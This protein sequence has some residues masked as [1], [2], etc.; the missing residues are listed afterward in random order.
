MQSGDIISS[1]LCDLV[2]GRTLGP[3]TWQQPL[4]EEADQ[5][6]GDERGAIL[7][8]AQGIWGN[9]WNSKKGSAVSRVFHI[10]SVHVMSRTTAEGESEPRRKGDTG[11]G[12][13]NQPVPDVGV[14]DRSS[15]TITS[16]LQGDSRVLCII[17]EAHRRF[18]MVSG[19]G[20]QRE[21][22]RGLTHVLL[23]ST[24]SGKRQSHG[25]RQ[26]GRGGGGR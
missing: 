16:C 23:H 13:A 17:Y 20:E 8:V 15:V 10:K 6:A 24:C 9:A 19:R 3:H 26:R 5:Y 1:P 11:A 4:R 25:T 18:G 21:A 22:S 2:K 7:K 12:P 14:I